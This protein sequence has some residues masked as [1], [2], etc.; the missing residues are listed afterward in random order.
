MSSP[1][2]FVVHS[3]RLTRIFGRWPSFHD[4]EVTEA[5]L[6]R[7]EPV[8]EGALSGSPTLTVKVH[9]WQ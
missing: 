5:H 1:P 4:A 2:H 7:G 3:E 6:S 8:M 9:L